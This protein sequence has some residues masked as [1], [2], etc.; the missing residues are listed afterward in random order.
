MFLLYFPWRC[1][2]I[3]RVDVCRGG[4]G[5]NE[6]EDGHNGYESVLDRSKGDGGSNHHQASMRN[7]P[8][9][10]HNSAVTF[11]KCRQLFRLIQAI[12]MQSQWIRNRLSNYIETIIKMATLSIT[13]TTSDTFSCDIMSFAAILSR[14]I[15]IMAVFLCLT[16]S[17]IHLVKRATKNR[18][19]IKSSVKFISNVTENK[20][21]L[22]RKQKKI[23]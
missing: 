3:M 21:K 12:K 23:E 18:G 15:A 7:P 20:Q 2:G 13:V 8:K 17:V 6:I 10:L 5:F 11:A 19:K 22:K 1:I 16:L 9:A 14:I 4:V